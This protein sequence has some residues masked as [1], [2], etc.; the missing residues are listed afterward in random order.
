M[1]L[2]IDRADVFFINRD[3]KFNIDQIKQFQ[4]DNIDFM[5]IYNGEFFYNLSLLHLF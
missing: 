5:S 3:A 4:E 1:N 2:V